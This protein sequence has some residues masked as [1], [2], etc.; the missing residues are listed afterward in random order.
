ME[1][2]YVNQKVFTQQDVLRTQTETLCRYLFV[3]EPEDT[4]GWQVRVR[5][6]SGETG[7]GVLAVLAVYNGCAVLAVIVTVSC[8]C[9]L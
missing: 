1:I 8:V 9:W 4:P 3:L 2:T 6:S 7:G 5:R